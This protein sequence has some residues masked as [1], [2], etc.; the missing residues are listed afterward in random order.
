MGKHKKVNEKSSNWG[1][2]ILIIVIA[3][4]LVGFLILSFYPSGNSHPKSGQT[5]SSKAYIYSI[6]EKQILNQSRTGNHLS[7]IGYV[8]KYNYWVNGKT[9]EGED[10]IKCSTTKDKEF[11]RYVYRHLNSNI[12]TVY[13]NPSEPQDNTLIELCE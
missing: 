10:Y 12:F 2:S 8:I 4:V 5:K 11:I 13:Y 3:V 1:T 6:E 9:F 7:T